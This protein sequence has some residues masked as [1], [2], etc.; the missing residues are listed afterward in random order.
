MIILSIDSG[1]E[2][3]GFAFFDKNRK[4]QSGYRFLSSGLITTSKNHQRE[5]RFLQLYNTIKG[6]I[7]KGK[8]NVLVVEQLFFS[9]NSKTAIPVAQSQGLLLLLAAQF[10][11]SVHFLTPPQI[12]QIITG[13]GNADKKSVQKMLAL[14]LNLKKPIVQDD[15][16][17][18][19]ACGLAFCCLNEN[20]LV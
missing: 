4:Y 14:L 16:A 13:Y 12:K 20:L 11:M 1:V 8:P 15:E 2:K 17:D 7:L 19:V 5:D 3:T 18:A 10:K 6:L 9:K